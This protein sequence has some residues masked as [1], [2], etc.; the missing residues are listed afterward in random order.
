MGRYFFNKIKF[1]GLFDRGSKKHLLRLQNY[2]NVDNR[3]EAY[4]SDFLY[5]YVLDRFLSTRRRWHK[6]KDDLGGYHDAMLRYFCHLCFNGELDKRS[7]KYSLESIL[8]PHDLKGQIADLNKR[9]DEFVHVRPD[10]QNAHIAKAES[11]VEQ[12]IM[13]VFQKC[14][15]NLWGRF[16]GLRF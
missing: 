11:L 6:G 8:N 12:L 7:I 9:R 1:F 10:A 4:K 15:D 14:D 3:L 2:D 16:E 5:D 13:Q